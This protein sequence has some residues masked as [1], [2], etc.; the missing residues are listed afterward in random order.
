MPA[1]NTKDCFREFIGM[2]LKGVLFDALPIGNI[3][4]AKG[5][6]TLIFEDGRGLTISSNGSYWLENENDIKR[7]VGSKKK[8]LDV[9]M[10]EIQ[11]VLST[12]GES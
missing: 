6:K 5:T 8:E 4:L 11:D 2:K 3:G 1:S 7:A 12:A 9:V 10:K